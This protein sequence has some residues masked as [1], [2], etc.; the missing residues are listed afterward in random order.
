MEET[1]GKLGRQQLCGRP[2]NNFKTQ[3][4]SS[5]ML[6]ISMRKSFGGDNFLPLSKVT[7][8]KS[9]GGGNFA[10]LSQDNATRVL[11]VT[12]FCRCHNDSI[13]SYGGGNLVLLP[14]ETTTKVLV[15]AIFCCCQKSWQQKSWWW[16]FRKA[17]TRISNKSFGGGCFLPLP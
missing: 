6:R 4:S 14:Q 1:P 2:C 15:V 17:A 7:T 9:L 5:T 3:K 13:Q 10:Q 16:Q 11:V 8:K 12:I